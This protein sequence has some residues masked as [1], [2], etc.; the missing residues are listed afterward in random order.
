MPKTKTDEGRSRIRERDKASQLIDF[1]G[2]ALD[3]GIYPTDID[4]LVE[5]KDKLYILF[6]IKF[7]GG[8]IHNGQRL[9][10]ERM[11][12][13]FTKAGKE[14]IAFIAMHNVTDLNKDIKAK[15]CLIDEF[16]Y[17]GFSEWKKVRD[18]TLTLETGMK[19]FK[20]NQKSFLYLLGYKGGG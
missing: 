16:Y 8:K 2:L 11:V 4:G 12:N 13:D 3:D 19:I 17:G 1:E 10:L 5:Y 9:A 14:A 20:T 18:T 15:Q 6:E 7:S